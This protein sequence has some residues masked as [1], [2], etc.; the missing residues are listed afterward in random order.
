MIAIRGSPRSAASYTEGRGGSDEPEE[1]ADVALAPVHVDEHHLE[2]TDL[3]GTLGEE[4]GRGGF[5]LPAGTRAI[6]SPLATSRAPTAAI[7]VA[8]S[9]CTSPREST[10]PHGAASTLGRTMI[11]AL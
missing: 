5:G 8:P 4:G 9:R 3:G 7:T 10:K 11:A 1:L 6:A 2:P